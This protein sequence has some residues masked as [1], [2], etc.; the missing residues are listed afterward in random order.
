MLPP[1]IGR[2]RRLENLF[3]NQNSFT[4]PLPATL[5]SMTWLRVLFMSSNPYLKGPLPTDI[6]N[7]RGLVNLVCEFCPLT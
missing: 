1:T 4:M 3:I 7:M 6:G 2:L 5:T